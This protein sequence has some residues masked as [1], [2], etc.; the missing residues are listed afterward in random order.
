V[1]ILKRYKFEIAIVALALLVRAILFWFS[2][3]DSGYSLNDTISGA[4]GYFVIAQNLVAGNGY[5]NAVEP[6]YALNSIRPPIQPYFIAG[7]YL[8]FGSYWGPLIIQM[9][10]GSLIPLLGAYIARH[11]TGSNRISIVAGVLLAL[12]PL[13]ALFSYIFYAETICTFFFLLSILTLFTYITERRPRMLYASAVLIGVATLA[14]PTVEFVPVLVVAA[15]A[16]HFRSAL[17]SEWRRIALYVVIFVLTLSPWIMRNYVEFGVPGVSPQLGEQLYAILVP[18]VLSMHNG[19]TFAEEFKK[20]LSEGAVDPNQ[21]DIRS[22]SVYLKKAVPIL[23]SHPQ[24]LIIV[25]LNTS[26][27]FFIHD[28]VFEVLK[29]LG[30]KPNTLLGKPA[31]FLL[32]SDPGKLFS[33][34]ASVAFQ[35]AI[36][37]LFARVFWI[38]TTVFFFAGTVRYVLRSKDV[39]GLLCI[40]I[41]FYFMLTTLV[42]GLAVTGRYHIPVEAFIFAIALYGAIPLVRRLSRYV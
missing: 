23:L 24:E 1:I 33:Y 12:E 39:R 7:M 22:A 3:A 42:I 41:V 26:L 34:I 14:K 32:L 5:S 25:S 20:I 9:I 30:L 29:N 18:S 16:W 19:T 13:A 21:A 4:D 27:N 15:L 28:G 6:P 36:F 8:L 11:I 38:I 2:F 40:G 17:R 10:M 35:P 31:L 37:I